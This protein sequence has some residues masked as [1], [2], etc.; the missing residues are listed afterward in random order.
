MIME[1]HSILS[2]I[3][4]ALSIVFIAILASAESSFIA[5]N[6]IRIRS[7]MEKGDSRAKAVQKL[8]DE[9]DKLFSAV[10]LSGNLFTILATSIGTVLA[11]R[12][13]GEDG[14]I[15]A[16]IIMT[17][18]TVVF[19]ELAPK[20]FAVTYSEKVSLLLAKPVAFYIRLISPLVWIFKVMSNLIIRMLGGKKKPISPFVTEEEI[21]TMINIGEEEGTLEEEEKQMLHKVF[22]FGDKVVTE[23]MVPRTE[24][25][26]IPDDAT[27]DDALKLVL[28]EGYSRYPVVKENIDSVTGILYVKDIVK[29]MAQGKIQNHTPITEIVREA[30]YIPENK[31]VTELLDEMQKNKFQIAIVMDEYGGTAGLI[32]LEDIMEEIVGGLQDEFEA[33]E[34]EKEFEIID[35]RTSIVAGQTGLDEINEL[36]GS[37]IVSE[38][39]HTIGGFVFGLFRRLP[40]VGEQARYH[41]LRF[42][43][44]EMEDRKIA[45]VKITRL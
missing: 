10:I 23:A 31:M 20:T 6:K 45:K 17:F 16:T 19:G 33:M 28:E 14:I 21:K 15:I 25:V 8:L 13:F 43:I 44:L 26:S 3:T 37:E 2:I 29:Q 24:I 9:H 7:L 41:N 30:Y 22:A 11:L 34:G 4:I 32:T 36:V 35:E 27:V 42:L 39:F 40:K 1:P 18:L 12:Y 38:D 5:V